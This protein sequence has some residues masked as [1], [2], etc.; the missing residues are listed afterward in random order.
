MTPFWCVRLRSS[1]SLIR[2]SSTVKS[3]HNCSSQQFGFN[4][5]NA[6]PFKEQRN[7][8]Q[9][10]KLVAVLLIVPDYEE[11]PPKQRHGVLSFMLYGQDPEGSPWGLADAGDYALDMCE[12]SWAGWLHHTPTIYHPHLTHHTP[13]QSMAR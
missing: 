8:I 2:A 1:P 10:R 7:H 11:L 4:D 13:P 3:Q 6:K 5:P 12:M 9:N